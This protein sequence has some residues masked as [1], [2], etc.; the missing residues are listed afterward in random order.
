MPTGQQALQ[1]ISSWRALLGRPVY[2]TCGQAVASAHPPAAC[3]I[4]VQLSSRIQGFSYNLQTNTSRLNDE[5]INLLSNIGASN[6]SI[7]SSFDVEL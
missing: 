4:Q 3:V 2:I 6:N 7:G 1:N 5:S